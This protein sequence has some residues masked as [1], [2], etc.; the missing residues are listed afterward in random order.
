MQSREHARITTLKWYHRHLIFTSIITY[1]I[2]FHIALAVDPGKVALSKSS[3]SPRLIT[4]R[5]QSSVWLHWAYAYGGDIGRTV[6][7]KE[8]IIGFRR[9]PH[10][11][12]QVLAQRIGQNGVLKLG[13]SIPPPFNGRVEVIS[14]NSTLVIHRLQYSDSSFQF[15]SKITVEID[16]GTGTV[17]FQ[18]DLL[19]NINIKVRGMKEIRYVYSA[20]STTV[21][22]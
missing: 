20:Y 12:L 15:I 14:S 9:T 13:S 1:L 4:T 22:G 5:K 8:Q 18:I 17:P 11:C 10:S 16:V 3:S 6:K 7:Y 21:Y 19:P 2:V